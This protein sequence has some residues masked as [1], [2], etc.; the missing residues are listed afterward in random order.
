MAIALVAFG[1]DSNPAGASSFVGIPQPIGIQNGDLVLVGIALPVAGVTVTPPDSTWTPVAATDPSQALAL[2]VW[3]TTALNLPPNLVFALSASCQAAGVCAAYRGADAFAPV[4]AARVAVTAASASHSV[5]ATA[6]SQAGEELALFIAGAASGTYTVAGGYQEAARKQQANATVEFQHQLRQ[7]AGA[8]AG[9]T[10]TFSSSVAG[11]SVVVALAPS[12]GRSSYD[13]VYQRL[14]DGLPRGI[15]RILDFTPTGDFYKLFWTIGSV[16][17]VGFDLVDLLRQE[18]AAF[19]A[20]YKLSDWERVLGLSRTTTALAGTVPQRQQQ[21]LGAWRAAAAKSGSRSTVQATL[22]PLLGYFSTTV[23]QVVEANA[24]ALKTAHSYGFGADLVVAGGGG[25]GSTT[26]YVPDGGTVSKM[27][28]QLTLPFS[29]AA[30]LVGTITLTA[31]NGKQVSWTGQAIPSG[32][33]Q[34]PIKLYGQA[35]AGVPV[36]GTWTLSVTNNNVGAVTLAHTGASLYVDG[37]ARGQ[38]TGG[39]IFDWGAYADPAHLGE[40][41]APAD[42]NAA[43]DKLRR[44]ALAHTVANLIQSISPWPDTDSGVH[45]AIPDECIPV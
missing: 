8:V 27:G 22:G 33:T 25:N 30:S 18:I 43:R 14:V 21:V 2:S 26:F 16:L 45:A 9:F 15:D 35:F 5:A 40:S 17:K 28:A 29:G 37:I 31:P 3:G 4:E 6:T 10:E 34:T 32:W 20:R 36:T 44:L 41:G 24:A 13:D 42:F 19:T 11:A 38:E 23:P 1:A 39:A 7:G 12:P